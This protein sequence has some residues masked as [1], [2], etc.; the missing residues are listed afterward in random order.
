MGS[1]VILHQ[2]RQ[3]KRNGGK[4]DQDHETDHVGRDERQDAFEDGREA[5][6]FDRGLDDEDVH[7]DGRMDEPEFDRHDD[8][9]SEPDR[10]ETERRDDGEDNG[11]GQNDHRHGVHEKAE[12]E[13]HQ[14][15]QHENDVAADPETS[16]EF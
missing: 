7:S 4:R 6:V 14:H 10:V 12:Y 3:V 11:H 8:D 9:D 5:Y 15:D 16:Q 2:A 13:I 1:E